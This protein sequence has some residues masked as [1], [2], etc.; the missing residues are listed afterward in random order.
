MQQTW[1]A[2]KSA[3]AADRKDDRVQLPGWDEAFAIVS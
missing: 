2:R 3:V 1:E